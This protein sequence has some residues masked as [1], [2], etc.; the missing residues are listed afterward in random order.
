MRSIHFFTILSL[1]T[2]L[3]LGCEQKE[4][5]VAP[6]S[7]E[8]TAAEVAEEAKAE[9]AAGEAEAKDA[10]AAGEKLARELQPL[11]DKAIQAI[12]D[13]KLDDAEKTL[14]DLEAKKADAPE[15]TQKQI[16]DLRKSFDAAKAA[17]GAKANI[18][19]L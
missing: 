1:A 14:K 5:G 4:E 19:T 10:A 18:P 2:A 6:E 3:L 8:G 11:I 15:P 16:E 12:K 13:G 17:E 9:T 7:V